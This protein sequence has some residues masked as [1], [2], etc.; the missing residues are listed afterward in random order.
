MT[1]K[2]AHT[3]QTTDYKHVD[4]QRLRLGVYIWLILCFL[5]MTLTLKM[6]LTYKWM[7]GWTLPNILSPGLLRGR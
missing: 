4:W 5:R 1:A 6:T 3:H 2:A 7:D